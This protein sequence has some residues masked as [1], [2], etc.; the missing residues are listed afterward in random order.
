MRSQPT[1]ERRSAERF[2]RGLRYL[3]METSPSSR[4]PEVI[5]VTATGNDPVA[6]AIAAAITVI[7]ESERPTTLGRRRARHLRYQSSQGV[8]TQAAAEA[9]KDGRAEDPRQAA[10]RQPRPSAATTFAATLRNL[11]PERRRTGR[12]GRRRGGPRLG[13]NDLRRKTGRGCAVHTHKT[14]IAHFFTVISEPSAPF[15]TV[16]VPKGRGGTG[17]LLGPGRGG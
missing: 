14:L 8:R 2:A 16:S 7:R 6:T 3:G 4:E 13:C 17:G 11:G 9:V 12:R 1:L 15:S 10:G 5:E